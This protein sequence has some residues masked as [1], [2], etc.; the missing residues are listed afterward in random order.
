MAIGQPRPA[1]ALLSGSGAKPPAG[2]EVTKYVAVEG[3]S[4]SK[5]AGK[6]LGGNTRANRDAICAA[7]PA[8]KLDANKV[9][10]GRT[11]LIPASSGT[12]SAVPSKAALTAAAPVAQPPAQPPAARGNLVYR[13]RR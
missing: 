12:V 4:V 9:I 3:D 13:Q 6:F 1:P 8:L 10:V 7:N 5:M 11:Y 2:G